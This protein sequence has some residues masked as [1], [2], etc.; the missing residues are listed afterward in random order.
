MKKDMLTISLIVDEQ[1]EVTLDVFVSDAPPDAMLCGV[2]LLLAE[3]ADRRP[4][5]LG[6]LPRT[7][8]QGAREAQ[9]LL[10]GAMYRNPVH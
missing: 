8:Q 3:L 9:A 10:E 6:E 4:D 2:L 7:I 5:V 1:N